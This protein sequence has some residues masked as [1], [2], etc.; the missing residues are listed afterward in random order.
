M[1]MYVMEQAIT[2]TQT[3]PIMEFHINVFFFCISF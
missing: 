2:V 3:N 1:Y